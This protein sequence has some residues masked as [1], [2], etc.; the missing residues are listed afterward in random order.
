MFTQTCIIRKNTDELIEMLSNLGDRK[1]LFT[2]EKN[3]KRGL[4]V[5][6]KFVTGLPYD[7]REFNLDKYLS[8]NKFIID[9]G[10]NEQLFLAIAALRDDSDMYQWFVYPKTK[11]IKLHGYFPQMIGMDGTRCIIIGYEWHI[12]LRNDLTERINNAIEC[13]EDKQF[14]PHKATVEELIEHF[15]DKHE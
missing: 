1:I 7:S 8:E 12:S 13:G 5:G 3:R 9:C 4:L 6:H 2:K 15:K 11:Y 10:T 14:L